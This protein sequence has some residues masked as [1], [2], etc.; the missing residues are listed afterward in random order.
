MPTTLNTP[1]KQAA[2]TGK[3]TGRH[4]LFIMLAFFGT[5]I[6]VNITMALLATGS[7]TGL[8]VKNSFVASQEFNAQQAGQQTAEAIGWQLAAEIDAGHLIVRLRDTAQRP[9]SDMDV[10]I[11]AGRPV[12]EGGDQPLPIVAAGQG[13]YRS[14]D[15]LPAGQ[16]NLT[17]DLA[18]PATDPG[19]QL[20]RYVRVTVSDL[21]TR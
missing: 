21:A 12:H 13:V 2:K 11:R 14:V 4:M 3:F 18:R 16:W 19:I 20:T 1:Q 8:V 7:W 6:A 10:T 17:I 9:L 15:P 5:V